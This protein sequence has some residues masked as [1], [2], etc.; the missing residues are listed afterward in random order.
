VPGTVYGF[1]DRF[2]RENHFQDH[3]VEFGGQFRTATDY[4]S[5]AIAFLT[6]PMTDTMLECVRRNGDV[7]RYD[8]ATN[9]L[10][11]CNRDGILKTFYRPDP[12]YHLERDNLAYFEEQCKK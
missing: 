2:E 7:L 10:A 12:K 6:V 1:I 3:E 8:T 4:E 9:T 11:I 5:A